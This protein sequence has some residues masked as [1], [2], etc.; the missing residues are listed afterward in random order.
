MTE[1]TEKTPKKAGLMASTALVATMTMLSR[2]L[3]LVRDVV[4]ARMLGASAGADAFFVA[5]KI[6]NFFRRLFAEGAFNQAFV[7]VLSEYRSKGSMAATKLLVDRVAG[8]LGTVV[9][10][11]TLVGMLAAAGVVW[12]FAPG[13]GDDPV[14]RALTVEMLRLTFPYLFFI[15]L[16]A[17]AGGILNS[18]NR[19]AVPAFTP[20][21][22]NLSLIG[23]ALFLAPQF[24][25]DRMAVA[26]AWGVLIAGV[27]QL[28]F[29][30]PFLA[31]LNLMPVPRMGW[32]DPGVRKIMTL[33]IPALFGA[34]VY[35]LNSLVNTV[36]ASLLETGSV[37]WLYYTD[38]LIELPLGIF[39]V[40]IGT[41]ILPSLSSKHVD[42]S[43]EAFS[44]TLD[45]AIRM[46][47]LIGLPAALA[48]AVLAEPLLST[49]F[50]YGEFTA[51]D[52][53]KTAE[54]LRAYSTGLL[55]AMLI[56]VLAPGFYAR[57]DTRTP[58]KIGVIAMLAN[59]AF[60]AM[61][62]W[63][64]HHVGLAT[65]MALSAWLN[66]GLLYLGLRRAGVY[67]PLKGWLLLWGRMVFAGIAMAA[68]TYWL[69]LQ[70]Q[71]W[72]EAGVW[73][74]IGWL[75][76]IVASGLA[77]YGTSLLVLGLRPRHLRR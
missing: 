56:K 63:E 3:G 17:F 24:A 29:Q 57:Q 48:L 22:L 60:G 19:F 23:C 68:V 46:V 49:L 5:L 47:L 34:S 37:T 75:S 11:I 66:A 38:R 7:P 50:Q 31:R 30:L 10:L 61:L 36:L 14:K 52:V 40:A 62:V 27:A 59:M 51:F 18:W 16:T 9:A 69:S 72:T 54:S 41:V 74:R 12:L 58:V 45:W 33:M 4:I 26:L 43:S 15:S 28:L 35:Q 6:P 76:L 32:S 65:A 39:A 44:R 73:N 42:A 21:L 13:F 70:T 55:A 67:Q 77:I 53:A 64:W 1:P 20:V 8:T 25:E 71:A 2:V